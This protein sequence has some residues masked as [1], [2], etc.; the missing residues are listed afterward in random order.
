MKDGKVCVKLYLR[1]P[2]HAKL[3]LAHRPDDYSNPIQ[4][5][6]G[7]SNLT[8]SGLTRQGELNAEF[9]DSDQARKFADWFDDRWN[10]R[11]CEDIT[12]ELVNVIDNSWAS[13]KDI[14]PYYVYLKVAYH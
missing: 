10:D 12:E 8:Y 7:S 14:P 13:E 4:S 9:G 1:E 2:L 3:Y 6:M 5:L 11:F